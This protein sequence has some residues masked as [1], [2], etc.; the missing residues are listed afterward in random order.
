ML[1]PRRIRLQRILFLSDLGGALRAGTEI[2][3]QSE[4]W[5]YDAPF[6]YDFVAPLNWQVRDLA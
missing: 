6:L 3:H 5:E 2:R 1:S 4:D